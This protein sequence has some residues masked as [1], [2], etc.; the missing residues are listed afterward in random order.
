MVHESAPCPS[1]LSNTHVQ[2]WEQWKLVLYLKGLDELYQMVKKYG[3]DNSYV[4]K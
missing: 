1:G 4:L 2:G 3:P